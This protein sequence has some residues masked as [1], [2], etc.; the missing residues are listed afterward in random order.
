MY[1]LRTGD[2][3]TQSADD[4]VRVKD[5]RTVFAEHLAHPEAKSLDPDGTTCGPVTRGLLGRRPIRAATISLLGK[6][7]N[8]LEEVESGQVLDLE[9]AQTVC[10]TV[11]VGGLESWNALVLPTLRRMSSAQI[12]DASG[13]SRSTVTAVLARRTRPMSLTEWLLEGLS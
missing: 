12:A 3:W 8:R 6:E 7:A 13:L 5:L 11:T 4:E 1:R 2:P 9:D 10:A